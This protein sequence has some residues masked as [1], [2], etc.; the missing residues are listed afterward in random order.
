MCPIFV[1]VCTRDVNSSENAKDIIEA[2]REQ[3]RSWQA[4]YSAIQAVF[5]LPVR[6]DV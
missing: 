4:K 5:Y 2:A 3:E 6:V 1:A